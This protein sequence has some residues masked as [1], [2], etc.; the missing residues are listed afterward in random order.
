MNSEL[1]TR[2]N[3]NK[4]YDIVFVKELIPIDTPT[5]GIF[6][7]WNGCDYTVVEYGWRSKKA[8]WDCKRL[9]DFKRGAYIYVP[10]IDEEWITSCKK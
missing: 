7:I 4:H 1:T 8:F 9:P 3:R 10:I 5:N 6:R 2:W